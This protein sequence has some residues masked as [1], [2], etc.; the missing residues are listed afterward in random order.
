MLHELICVGVMQG[1]E[2]CS[3]GRGDGF[4]DAEFMEIDVFIK[5]TINAWLG[6]QVLRPFYF[7]IKIPKLSHFLSLNHHSLY[8]AGETP[9]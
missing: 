7:Y 1:L 3:K 2:L 9:S 5:Y 4:S 6:A 8:G